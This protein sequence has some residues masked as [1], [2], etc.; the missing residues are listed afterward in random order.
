MKYRYGNSI[1]LSS[2]AG[3]RMGCRFCASTRAG[4]VRNLTA[5]EIVSQLMEAEAATGEKI[6]HIVVMGTGEPFDNY[7]NLAG[8]VR[9]VTTP[10]GR[11]MSMRNITVSTCGIVPAI[12]RFGEDFPQVNLAVSLHGATDEVRGWR[13]GRGERL[14]DARKR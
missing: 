14:H 12:E 8:F 4:L 11:G 5:G 7:E 1:C 3:C 10:E 13:H 2:Q 6:N 9:I